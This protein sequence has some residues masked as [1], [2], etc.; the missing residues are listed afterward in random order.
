MT[1]IMDKKFIKEL[2][3]EFVSTYSKF[4]SDSPLICGTIINN[5]IGKPI[6]QRKLKMV[7]ASIFSLL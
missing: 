7:R 3:K 4:N 5:A 2:K 1:E 6:F